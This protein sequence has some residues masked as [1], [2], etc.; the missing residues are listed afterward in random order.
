MWPSM[1]GDSTP[2][3]ALWL[4]MR[5]EQ[6]LRRALPDPDIDE[7]MLAS[8]LAT[9]IRAAPT[10]ERRPSRVMLAAIAAVVVFAA[11][12]VAVVVGPL[13][14][15]GSTPA[16]PVHVNGPDTAEIKVVPYAG[17]S[18][19]GYAETPAWRVDLPEGASSAVTPMGVAAVERATFKLYGIADGRPLMEAPLDAPVA[20]TSVAHVN[21]TESLVWRTGNALH[22]WSDSG[23]GR[24]DIPT[25]AKLSTAGEQVLMT[26][27]T[28]AF[29]V[30][31]GGTSRV[32]APEGKTVLAADRDVAVAASDASVSFI[33]LGDGKES[34]F[35]PQSPGEGLQPVRWITAGRGVVVSVWA[36]VS[37]PQPSFPLVVAVHTYDGAL[38]GRTEQQGQ[39][40]LYSSWLRTT[41]AFYGTLDTLAV[42]I[43]NRAARWKCSSCVMAGGFGSLVQARSPEGEGYIS[44][45][46]LWLTR[47]KVLG[48]NPDAGVVALADGHSVVGYRRQGA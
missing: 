29:V 16:V 34:P 33:G 11:V 26:T 43:R 44:D 32:L 6:S 9:V 22:W 15:R 23:T 2:S 42:D 47:N 21:S 5:P 46:T 40:A 48:E 14:N 39:V 41:G 8:E 37:N 31:G 36:K 10:P 24:V 12:V 7:D 4:S 38:V 27:G 20:F 45:G 28:G 25:D 35:Q 19:P 17:V 30:N 1:Q 13:T 18:A 3:D